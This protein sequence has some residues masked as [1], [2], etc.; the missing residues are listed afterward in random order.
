M[1]HMRDSFGQSQNL[2][3]ALGSRPCVR[4]TSLYKQ[5]ES[6][7]AMKEM[8]GM[9]HLAWDQQDSPDRQLR[10]RPSGGSET[11]ESPS[12][13]RGGNFSDTV[14]RSQ[15]ASVD[16]IR[17]P[18]LDGPY[19]QGRSDRHSNGSVAYPQASD[20]LG[21]EGHP[22]RHSASG[23]G[24]HKGAEM[25]A[26]QRKSSVGMGDP[27]AG[28]RFE[29]TNRRAAQD[30]NDS[31]HNVGGPGF[32]EAAD[33][34]NF[35]GAGGAAYTKVEAENGC[36]RMQSTPGS[37]GTRVARGGA[38]QS[39]GSQAAS[40]SN[41]RPDAQGW[42]FY[43]GRNEDANPR[44]TGRARVVPAAASQQASQVSVTPAPQVC[45]TSSAP[46]TA[47]KLSA[48]RFD[49]ARVAPAFGDR[50]RSS[51]FSAEYS[52]GTLPCRIDH[53]TCTNRISWDLPLEQV[54]ARRDELL[55]LC[56]EGLR[57]TRHPYNVVS[58]L[59][60]SDLARLG[61]GGAV[62]AMAD[63]HLRQVMANLRLALVTGDQAKAERGQRGASTQ[64]GPS[65]CGPFEAALGALTQ[66]AAAEGERVCPHLHL[67]LPPIGKQLFS[68]A[69]RESIQ[70]CL[71]SVE[72]YGGPMASKAMQARGVT[73]GS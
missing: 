70:A 60:F 2:G 31:H 29:A 32:P 9:G 8:L 69:Y 72:H 66:L 33:P 19:P 71:R 17:Q 34:R 54:A 64:G 57:E 21:C 45:R 43:G 4:Q 58:R 68:R 28:D 59:A 41:R 26:P 10:S 20:L 62:E 49:A 47:P 35:W 38:D 48:A 55:V 7:N 14:S 56:S 39:S 63:E 46:T 40:S 12:G 61:E 15:T 42:G 22:G 3:N 50:S 11:K 16:Q 13:F 5:H 53:G 51:H 24:Y 23:A 44:S 36:A 67:V 18:L 52:R 37:S 6:G 30:Y 1:S 25:Q 73:P 27:D 65:H